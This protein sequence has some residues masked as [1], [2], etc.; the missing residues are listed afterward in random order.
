MKISEELNIAN[1]YFQEIISRDEARIASLSIRSSGPEWFK[2][3]PSQVHTATNYMPTSDI[4]Y[5]ERGL[6]IYDRHRECFFGNIIV[7]SNCTKLLPINGL[8][9]GSGRKTHKVQR[10]LFN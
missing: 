1:S 3:N 6:H 9:I 7:T 4:L 2:I 10:T 5:S 8:T